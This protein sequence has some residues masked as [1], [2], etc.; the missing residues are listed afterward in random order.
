MHS[1]LVL[2]FAL[3]NITNIGKLWSYHLQV[4]V[5]KLRCLV[6]YCGYILISVGCI[7]I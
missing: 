7:P 5:H 4:S 1:T 3:L 6:L 2:Q